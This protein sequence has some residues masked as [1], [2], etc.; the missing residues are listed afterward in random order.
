[1][2]HHETRKA[3]LLRRFPW[4]PVRFVQ[5]FLFI[6]VVILLSP[7]LQKTPLL[8]ALLSVFFL[9]ILIVTLSFAGFDIRRRWPLILLWFLGILM[10][11]AAVKIAAHPY[12]TMLEA[13]A[14]LVNALLTVVCV[15]MIL[16]YVLTSREVTVDTVFGALVAYFLIALSFSSLYQA[17]SVIEP[18]SFSMPY[19]ADVAGGHASH[20]ELA[21]F[22]FVTIATLGYGD[23][24]PRLPA[25]QML[26]ILEAVMGQFYMAVVV[27]W[28]VSVL[29]LRRK[30]D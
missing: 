1:M 13:S 23:I 15:V 16:R 9:N 5:L 26:S 19:T 10:D 28:L 29:V 24:V 17:L 27:A 6:I 21:Y 20:M 3:G 2:K 22:S 7:V 11:M 8:I 18:T 25:A 12:A 30:E 14:D 4:K